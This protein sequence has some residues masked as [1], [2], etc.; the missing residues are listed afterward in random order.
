MDIEGYLVTIK[1]S[2]HQENILSMQYLT[3]S[4]KIQKEK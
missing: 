1:V 4:F 2:I 3:H